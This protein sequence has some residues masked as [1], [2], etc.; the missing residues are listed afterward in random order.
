MESLILYAVLQ[1]INDL[2]L[3]IDLEKT[4]EYAEGLYIQIKNFKNL[5]ANICEILGFPMAEKSKDLEEPDQFDDTLVKTEATK[6]NDDDL[7]P[8]SSQKQPTMQRSTLKTNSSGNNLPKNKSYSFKK[9]DDTIEL[10]N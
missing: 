2:S 6:S 5:P 3:R 7:A 9:E 4:L 1:F 8:T 10:L